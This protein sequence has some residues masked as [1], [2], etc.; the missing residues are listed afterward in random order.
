[1]RAVEKS[2]D[3]PAGRPHRVVHLVVDGVQRIHVEQPARDARLVGR[4]H[5]AV[6]RLRQPGDR[7]QTAGNGLPFV[8][9]LDETLGVEIDD[10]V[11]VENDEVHGK[12]RLAGKMRF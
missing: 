5:H 8:R 6:A 7:L 3:P 9:R 10:A 2:V 12:T 4:D 11:A 1:V